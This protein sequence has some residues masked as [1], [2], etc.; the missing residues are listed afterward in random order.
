MGYD[1]WTVI[2]KAQSNDIYLISAVLRYLN[3]LYSNN[4]M[5]I[6]WVGWVVGS[7]LH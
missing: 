7:Y 1:L 2:F 4:K 5:K 3:L 6:F